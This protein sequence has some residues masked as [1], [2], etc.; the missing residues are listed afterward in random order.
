MT[1]RKLI[2]CDVCDTLY[3]SNT[4]FDFLHFIFAKEKT[5]KL[6]L[7]ILVSKWSPVFYSLILS[8]KLARKDF[9]RIAALR[10]L[11]GKSVSEIDAFAQSFY[12]EIL[13]KKANQKIFQIIESEEQ[14][15]NVVLISSS[16][17]PVIQAIGKANNLDFR[18]SQLESVDGRL[19]GR[20]SLD[21]THLKDV[22]VKNLMDERG[23]EKLLVITDNRSDWHLVKMA[24]ERVIVVGSERDKIFWDEL[25]PE[26][27]L[28]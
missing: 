8:G 17:L 4:T 21:L 22:V 27:I 7:N 24:D 23:I 5:R 6:F 15:D 9:I 13:L 16:I 14:R 25:K 11:K 28:T 1:S 18:S 20:L 12:E 2:V 19:T 10:L 26:F 3:R